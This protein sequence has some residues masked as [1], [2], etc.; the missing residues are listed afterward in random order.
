[1]TANL[2]GAVHGF[3]N[4]PEDSFAR[5]K[6][7]ITTG[8]HADETPPRPLGWPMTI[9]ATNL[10]HLIAEDL[11]SVYTYLKRAPSI[12]GSL[13]QERQRYARYCACDAD[14]NAAESC[15]LATSEC[16]GS[17]CRSNLD[18]DACQTCTHDVCTAPVATSACLP[19]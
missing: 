4:E 8:T 6:A 3:F 5:F 18:C 12:S 14:C 9:I 13:D 17:A 2:K 11:E 15:A 7:V 1:M 16:V 19:L 10:S